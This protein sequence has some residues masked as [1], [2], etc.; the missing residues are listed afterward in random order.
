[1]KAEYLNVIL[2]S[3]INVIKQWMGKD[4][5]LAQKSLKHTPITTK[6]LTVVV[7]VN[8]DLS[9]N[10]FISFEAGTAKKLASSMAGG[11]VFEEIDELCKSAIGEIGNV[12]MGNICTAFAEKGKK[13]DITPPVLVEGENIKLGTKYSP[14]VSLDLK[15]VNNEEITLDISLSD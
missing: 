2:T 7:G 13:I 5:V 4:F 11:F 1:M 15:S 8:G 3:T 14:L 9:G 12:I 6:P 10:V